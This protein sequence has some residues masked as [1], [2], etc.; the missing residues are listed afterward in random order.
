MYLHFQGYNKL[1]AGEISFCAF[2]N[3]MRFWHECNFRQSFKSGRLYRPNFE[4][5]RAEI[6]P[7]MRTLLIII[8]GHLFFS[9][10]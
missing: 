3:Y 5:F 6:G 7:K 2:S 4:R 1:S 9:F 8:I 10:K